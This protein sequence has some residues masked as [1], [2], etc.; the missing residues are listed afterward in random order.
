MTS[1]ALVFFV[2]T[3][4]PCFPENNNMTHRYFALTCYIL[5]CP[6]KAN[7]DKYKDQFSFSEDKQAGQLLFFDMISQIRFYS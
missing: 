7:I 5:T 3:I 6:I 1:C 4:M 2:R